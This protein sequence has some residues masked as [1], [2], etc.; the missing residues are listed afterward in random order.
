MLKRFDI[1]DNNAH[2]SLMFKLEGS[3]ILAGDE[4][5][6]YS[7]EIWGMY[8][9]SYQSIGAQHKTLND[10]LSDSTHWHVAW[11]EVGELCAL[12]AYRATKG[13]LKAMAMASNGK[14]KGKASACLL[15]EQMKLDGFYGEFSGKPETIARRLGLSEVGVETARTLISH[16]IVPLAG[17]KAYLRPITGIGT[18]RKVM[19]GKPKMDVDN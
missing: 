11:D 1:D 12:V 19:F 5:L 10:L 18:H 8:L 15:M 14:V 2:N 7:K 17:G 13:G 9:L 4:R 16:P 3:E 6:P